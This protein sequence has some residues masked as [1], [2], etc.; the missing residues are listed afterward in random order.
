MAKSIP[1]LVNPEVLKWARET[2]G[3]TVEEIADKMK[4]S[5]QSIAAWETGERQPTLS[6]AKRIAKYYRIPYVQFFLSEVP[7]KRK[8]INKEDFRTFGNIGVPFGM[9]KELRWLL[10]DI[11][12]RR[13]TMIS[14]YA[15]E[16]KEVVPFP[17]KMDL[18]TNEEDI[19][20]EIRNLLQLDFKTQKEFRES[21][22][23]L[24]YCCDALE[25]YDIL[26]FQADKIDPQEMRGVSVAYDMMPIIVLNRKDEQSARLF[27]LCHELV[28]VITRTSGICNNVSEDSDRDVKEIEI[29]CN[30]IAGK[31]LVPYEDFITDPNVKKIKKYGYEDD[32]IIAISKNFAVSREVILHRLLE[33]NYISRDTYFKILERYKKEYSEHNLNRNKKSGYIPPALNIGTQVGKLYSKEVLTAYYNEKITLRDASQCLLN[34]KGRHFS[35]LESWCF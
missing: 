23:A 2:A 31:A 12:D 18:D 34:L 20:R 25:K 13:D 35:K 19:A 9:S 28:H 33:L 27:T 11:E 30:R 6:Q 15:E 7:S 29:L 3:F 8:T 24:K 5:S 14:L 1:A 26:I 17:V 22:R 21:S 10:R 32:Y 4:V 16:E